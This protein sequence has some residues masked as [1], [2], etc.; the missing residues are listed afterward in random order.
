MRIPILLLSTLFLF[1]GCKP[2]K[3]EIPQEIAGI[4]VEIKAERLEQELFRAKSKEEVAAF[5]Q[6]HPLFTNHFLQRKRYASEEE[7]VNSL[8]GMATE[9]N[10]QQLAQQVD[11]RF[12]D[13]NG[14][15]TDLENAFKHLKHYYPEAKV[16]QLAT[17]ITGMGQDLYLDDSLLVWG[18]DFFIGPEAKYRPPFPKYI[19]Y[20]YDKPY[21]VPTT[22][23]LLSSRYNETGPETNMLSEMI[24]NGKSLYFAQKLLPCTPDSLLMGYTNQEMADVYYNQERIWGHFVEKGLLFETNQFKIKKYVGE[25][26][27]VPEIGK[28][29]PGRIGAWVGWQIVRKYMEEHPDVTLPQLMAETNAQK[30]LTASKYK[31]KKQ[32]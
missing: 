32:G 24:A 29:C 27:N 15:E 21:L 19:L 13:L 9:P 8:Y 28:Q 16:P 4:P 26:P 25:R 12:S 1:F 2:Q 18:L 5:L 11:K 30:I 10:L 31:P 14:L 6:K 17:F 23:L 20:R 7:L 22:V 3:C